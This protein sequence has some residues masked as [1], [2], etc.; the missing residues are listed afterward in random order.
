[1]V[2]KRNILTLKIEIMVSMVHIIHVKIFQIMPESLGL[3]M[4][5]KTEGQDQQPLI[6]LER[7]VNVL[8][9]SPAMKNYSYH[10]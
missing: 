3:E 1:M 6:F 2:R 10:S 8:A 9:R 4:N 7:G 5:R